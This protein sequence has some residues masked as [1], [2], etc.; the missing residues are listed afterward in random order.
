MNVSIAPTHSLPARPYNAVVLAGFVAGT[1]DLIY[2]S[3]FWGIQIGFTPLQILQSIS[4]GWMGRDAAYAGGYSSA[5]L[6]LVSHYGIAI[7]MAAVFY[8]A[9]RRWRELARKPFLYGSLYG[10]A[11]YAVMT[12]VIVPLSNAGAGQLPA[13]RWENLSHIA[14][15]MVLVGIPCALGARRA[16]AP[17]AGR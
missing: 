6:G 12:Y 17:R 7:T 2:A 8:L 3:T 1:L 15:H 16:M 4:S 9:C 5:L 10:A 11:L 14:G 13:W